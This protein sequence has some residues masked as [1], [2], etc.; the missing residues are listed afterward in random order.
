MPFVKHEPASLRVV[1]ALLEDRL[2]VM[3][4]NKTIDKYELMEIFEKARATEQKMHLTLG[5]S[6]ASDRESKPAPEQVI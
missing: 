4:A 5:E 2:E 6:T 1:I 3:Y